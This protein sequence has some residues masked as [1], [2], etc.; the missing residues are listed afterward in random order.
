[1]SG[2]P[3]SHPTKIFKAHISLQTN[4]FF[5]INQTEMGTHSSHSRKGNSSI[6]IVLPC[7]LKDQNPV[8]SFRLKTH[9]THQLNLL[10][11]DSSTEGVSVSPLAI[12]HFQ[13]QVIHSSRH[14]DPAPQLPIHSHMTIW[15]DEKRAMDTKSVYRLSPFD[16]KLYL[17]QI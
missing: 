4:S 12:I 8:P 3:F 11:T 16:Q 9:F 5:M 17:Y 7:D 14:L 13:I 10:S 15:M 1:M 6:I 2:N